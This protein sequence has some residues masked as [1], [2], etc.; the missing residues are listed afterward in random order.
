MPGGVIGIGA[1]LNK[2]PSICT[3]GTREDSPH[4][5]LDLSAQQRP[6][7]CS[8]SYLS[9]VPTDGPS[10]EEVKKY[11]VICRCLDESAR[12]LALSTTKHLIAAHH[13]FYVYC[14]LAI[15][16]IITYCTED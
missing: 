12:T 16:S 9:A 14:L 6:R 1:A 11:D 15:P 4:A 13:Y 8:N 5:Q 3:S 7:N 2:R 10:P